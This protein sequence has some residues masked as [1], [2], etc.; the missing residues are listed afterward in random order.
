MRDI[1]D[2]L[3][4]IQEKAVRADAVVVGNPHYERFANEIK[5]FAAMAILLPFPEVVAA[6][7]VLIQLSYTA[8]Y[9]HGQE[10]RMPEA[11]IAEVEHE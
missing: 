2:I 7:S 9:E 5:E 10:L 3:L 11:I 4:S 1:P 6:V 8:G